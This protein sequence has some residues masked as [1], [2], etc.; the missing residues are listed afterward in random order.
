MVVA[1]QNPVEHHGTYPL[2]ESQLDRFLMR[3]NIGYPDRASERAILRLG[4]SVGAARTEAGAERGRS[5]SM[6][7][8]PV[9]AVSVDESLVSYMLRNRPRPRATTNRLRSASAPRGAQ[10]L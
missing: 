5:C 9:E 6:R 2:P 4:Q 7:S 1:T 3:L 10:A 8:T